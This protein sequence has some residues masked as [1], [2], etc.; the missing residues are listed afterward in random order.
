MEFTT[1]CYFISSLTGPELGKK[2]WLG[3]FNI[4]TLRT[5]QYASTVHNVQYSP[6]AAMHDASAAVLP[7]PGKDFRYRLSG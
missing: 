1:K 2:T 3:N 5:K 4:Q 7:D 6:T